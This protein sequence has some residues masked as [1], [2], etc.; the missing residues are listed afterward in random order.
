M[1]ELTEVE[2]LAEPEVA[3]LAPTVVGHHGEVPEG[4]GPLVSVHCEEVLEGEGQ[5]S[6]EVV[7]LPHPVVAVHKRSE[8][9]SEARTGS[10]HLERRTGWEQL[11]AELAC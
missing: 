8:A 1:S 3:A 10:V 9:G 11:D 4:E 7:Q 2:E 5:S 6:V